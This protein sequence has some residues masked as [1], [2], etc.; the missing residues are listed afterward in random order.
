[1]TDLQSIISLISLLIIMRLIWLCIRS[2]LL[3][4][5][6][7]LPSH[8]SGLSDSRLSEQPILSD[9]FLTHFFIHR[10]ALPNTCFVAENKIEFQVFFFSVFTTCVYQSDKQS[11][12]LLKKEVILVFAFRSTLC[13]LALNV[14]PLQASRGRS[15]PVSVRHHR[16]KDITLSL[17]FFAF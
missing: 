12:I 16:E 17:A 9:L 4:V 1:M 15:E 13:I 8:T 5:H 2:L 10:I 7:S 11:A 14:R 3:L 6:Q